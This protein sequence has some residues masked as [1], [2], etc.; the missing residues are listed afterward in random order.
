MLV[1]RNFNS[2]NLMSKKSDGSQVKE[3]TDSSATMDEDDTKGN[4]FSSHQLL[5][6][7]SPSKRYFWCWIVT[8]KIFKKK[9]KTIKKEELTAVQ[10]SLPKNQKVIFFNFYLLSVVSGQKLIVK[11]IFD[12]IL[13]CIVDSSMNFWMW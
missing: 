1:S 7:F 8:C 11:T 3:S 2:K 9:K 12:Y 10:Q 4:K 13:V 5:N 6:S